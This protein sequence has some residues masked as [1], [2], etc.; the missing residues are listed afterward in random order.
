[1]ARK[2][3]IGDSVYIAADVWI[4]I[5]EGGMESQKPS[6]TFG[7]G[8]KI[9]RRAVIS[10]KNGIC[11]ESD[12]VLGPSVLIMDHNHGYYNAREPIHSQGTT[13]GGSIIIERNCWIGHGAAIICGKGELV[14]GHNCVVGANAV[15]TKSVPACSVIVGNPGRVVKAYDPALNE[16]V[17]LSGTLTPMGCE[18]PISE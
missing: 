13:A 16:W 8:C 4:N 12:V 15:V 9:G 5:V 17:S 2:I 3:A 1:M 14:I 7:N 18:E 6:I 10:S 11:V